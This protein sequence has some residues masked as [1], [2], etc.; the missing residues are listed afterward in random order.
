MP[1]VVILTPL[2]VTATALGIYDTYLSVV[3]PLAAVQIPF[4][5]CWGGTSS[6]ASRTIDA[7]RVHGATTWKAS[8]Y[9]MWLLTFPIGAAIIV[10]TLIG[11]WGD[12]LLP[13]VSLQTPR[14]KR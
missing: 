5:C 3:L 4:R 7:D 2:L 9:I 12:F 8:R 13:L 10:L 11:T 14:C 1:E 6:T